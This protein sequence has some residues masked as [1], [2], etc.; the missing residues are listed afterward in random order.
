MTVWSTHA[1]RVNRHGRD[2]W[3]IHPARSI[4]NSLQC[5]KIRVDGDEESD[6]V[7][8][9][10]SFESFGSKLKWKEYLTEQK[11]LAMS[12]F[13]RTIRD[14]GDRCEIGLP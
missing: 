3:Q 2:S 14:V 7:E 10:W 4:Q 9:F 6:V 13:N 12:T 1:F 11:E 8:Q 5:H